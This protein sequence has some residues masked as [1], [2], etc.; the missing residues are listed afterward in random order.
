MAIY[1]AILTDIVGSN[2]T[3]SIRIW[4]ISLCSGA[5]CKIKPCRCPIQGVLPDILRIQYYRTNINVEVTEE[6]LCLSLLCSVECKIIQFIKTGKSQVQ[7][8]HYWLHLLK[9]YLLLSTILW[10]NNK[11]VVLSFI[12]LNLTIRT[13]RVII[14]YTCWTSTYSKIRYGAMKSNFTKF[15][16]QCRNIFL[17]KSWTPRAAL[18]SR[19]ICRPL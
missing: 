2:S 15:R 11:N 10:E 16:G 7:I 6:E 17:L 8:H 18:N 1:V 19:Y 12:N 4:R 5:L 14:N 13:A 9:I 3:Y